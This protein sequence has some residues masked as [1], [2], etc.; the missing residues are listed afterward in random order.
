MVSLEDVKMKSALMMNGKPV[1]SSVGRNEKTSPMW[2]EGARPSLGKA[3]VMAHSEI[4]LLSSTGSVTG[5]QPLKNEVRMGVR[6]LGNNV[7][8]SESD[9]KELALIV[10]TNAGDRF[11][12]C[13]PQQVLHCVAGLVHN[14]QLPHLLQEQY[15]L[16]RRLLELLP[17]RR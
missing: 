3:R 13:D 9:L 2:P 8:N 16:G 1:F 17:R 14:V 10:R 5:K 11:G 7:V 12:A 6:A 15:D 4:S